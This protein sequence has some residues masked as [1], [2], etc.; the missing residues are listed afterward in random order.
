[1]TSLLRLGLW[2]A[3]AYVLVLVGV[4]VGVEVG[5]LR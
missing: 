3:I 5:V 1:M 4:I 2:M